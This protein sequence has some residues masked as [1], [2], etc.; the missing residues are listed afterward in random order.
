MKFIATLIALCIASTCYAGDAGSI[1]V[2]R[3]KEP[4]QKSAQALDLAAGIRFA[5]ASNLSVILSTTAAARIAENEQCA[6]VAA[7]VS[8]NPL[9]HKF[10]ASETITF[11]YAGLPT[12]AG[13]AAAPDAYASLHAMIVSGVED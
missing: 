12:A 7:K 4:G 3:A 2:C 5:D 10:N 8:D 13:N 1:K 6:E 11:H 9:N